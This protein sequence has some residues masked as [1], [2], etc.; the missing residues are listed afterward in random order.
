GHGDHLGL[1]RFLAEGAGEQLRGVLLDEDTGFEIEA[2]GESEVL[3]GGAG[4]AVDA[5]VFTTSVWIDA[6]A[7]THVGTVVLGQDRA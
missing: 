6:E 3:V 5:A 1:P 2:G 7:K 4:V